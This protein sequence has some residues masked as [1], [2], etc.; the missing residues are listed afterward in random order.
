VVNCAW[1]DWKALIGRDSRPPWMLFGLF[2]V[3]GRSVPGVGYRLSEIGL[4]TFVV[5]RRV[6]LSAIEN[7]AVILART[8]LSR[9]DVVVRL[10]PRALP[11]CR[12]VECYGAPHGMCSARAGRSRG[13]ESKW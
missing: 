1:C 4:S 13:R 9:P 7:A 6:E 11:F 5:P 3:N 2:F 12:R 10:F 8:A